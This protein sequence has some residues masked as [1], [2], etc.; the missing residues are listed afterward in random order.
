MGDEDETASREFPDAGDGDVRGD[1]EVREVRD[2]DGGHALEPAVSVHGDGDV[3]AG[4][5]SGGYVVEGPVVRDDGGAVEEAIDH[6]GVPE[7]PRGRVAAMVLGEIW[8]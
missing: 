8:D 1:G 7:E 2:D 4:G 5:N 3:W 6:D